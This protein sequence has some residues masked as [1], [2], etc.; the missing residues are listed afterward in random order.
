MLDILDDLE[1]R[2]EVL[3][4]TF[5]TCQNPQKEIKLGLKP[6]YNSFKSEHENL[7]RRARFRRR[8]RPS[9]D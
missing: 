4:N 1:I 9:P 3:Q 5:E 6:N 2:Q 7:C 8:S